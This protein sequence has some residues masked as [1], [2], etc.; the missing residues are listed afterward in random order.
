MII[1]NCQNVM[2]KKAE[3]GCVINSTDTDIITGTE[4]WLSTSVSSSKFFHTEYTVY[5]RDRTGDYGGVVLAHKSSYNSHQLSLDSDCEIITCQI[6][7]SDNPL[8]VLAVY[9]PPKSDFGYLKKLCL[10]LE[11]ICHVNPSAVVWLG[12]DLILPDINWRTNSVV[13]H[14]YPLCMNELFMNTL[15]NCCL[16]QL[17]TFPT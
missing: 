10:V 7:L 3:L 2:S 1:I 11:N 4:T 12:G 13:H 6:D 17:V 14:Q 15:A 9:R 5:H 16:S 8:I